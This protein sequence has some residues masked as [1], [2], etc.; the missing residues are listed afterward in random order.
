MNLKFGAFTADFFLTFKIRKF[1]P[2]YRASV[3]WFSYRLFGYFGKIIDH[4]FYFRYNEYLSNI[5]Y[6]FP[7]LRRILMFK[8]FYLIEFYNI[9]MFLRFS[10]GV[11]LIESYLLNLYFCKFV[12]FFWSAS[13]YSRASI[14]KNDLLSLVF[15][16]SNG[17]RFFYSLMR[18]VGPNKLICFLYYFF[19]FSL[20]LYCFIL[21][22]K[23]P[24]TFFFTKLS[25]VYFFSFAFVAFAIGDFYN[26][27][28][29]KFVF[30]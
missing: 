22:S 11:F 4:M 20:V 7:K 12:L 9:R 15:V 6:F 8:P 27:F 5:L 18:I 23:K 28:F 13:N 29:D 30:F 19:V 26:Y 10:F 24:K 21:I 25:F 16:R 1:I 14:Y 17:F 3:A 2:F